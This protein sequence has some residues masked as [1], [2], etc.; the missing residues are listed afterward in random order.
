MATGTIKIRY[1]LQVTRRVRIQTRVRYSAR[2]ITTVR[3]V[4]AEARAR[5]DFDGDQ[6]QLFTSAY[7]LLPPGTDEDEVRDAIDAACEEV[8]EED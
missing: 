3:S 4:V 1:K 5:G 8:D 2:V 6:E 7:A